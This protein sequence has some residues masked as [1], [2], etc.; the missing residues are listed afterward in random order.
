M[1]I[2]HES[3]CRSEYLCNGRSGCPAHQPSQ[4]AERSSTR[5]AD[6]RRRRERRRAAGQDRHRDPPQRRRDDRPGARSG[7]IGGD[8]SATDILTTL[9][10]AVLRVDPRRRTTRGATASSSARAIAPRRSIRLSRCAASSRPTDLATFMQPLSALNGHP[11]RRKV[12]GVEAN[13]GPLGHGLPIGVGSAI[14]S[15]LCRRRTGGPSSSS[16]TASFRKARTGRR[17]CA[18]ATAGSTR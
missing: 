8:L 10:F 16:A 12:P 5:A 13:T 18:P 6:D 14:A 2:V 1:R 9:F 15:T 4:A 11:N 3:Q 17:R 7:H